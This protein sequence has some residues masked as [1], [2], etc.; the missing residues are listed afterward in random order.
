M[1]TLSPAR[2]GGRRSPWFYRTLYDIWFRLGWRSSEVV[3]LRFRNLDFARQVIRVEA[4]RMP[5]FGGIEAEPKTGPREV[6][7]SYDPRIFALFDAVRRTKEN[8]SPDDYVFTDPAGRPLSQKWLHKRVRLI[9]LGRA[10][11]RARGQYNIRDT[12]IS[13]A[14]SAGEDPGWV[15]KV[16]GTSEEMIFRHYRT[17]I[18]GLN[19]DA[20]RKVSRVL[21]TVSGGNPPPDASPVA[22][23]AP[24]STAEAQRDQLLKRVE[25]GGIEPAGRGQRRKKK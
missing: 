1:S 5:R 3:A 11:L 16:C 14:L 22:S 21:E 24:K 23:P 12:F 7:C 20:G 8:P 15:A 25:A 9:T 19:P 10:G 6:D 17:W 4:G 2:G 18:P 13:I